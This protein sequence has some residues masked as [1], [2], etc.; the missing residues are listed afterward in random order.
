MLF[1]QLITDF[2]RTWDLTAASKSLALSEAQ[3]S[4]LTRARVLLL[5]D[6]AYFAALQAQALCA[7]PMRR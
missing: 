6:R 7:S 4:L 3:R 2:G 5:V 1:N